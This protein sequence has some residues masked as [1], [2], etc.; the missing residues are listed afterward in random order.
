MSENRPS[1]FRKIRSP[2]PA[3]ARISMAERDYPS[4]GNANTEDVRVFVS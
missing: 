4:T 2:I 1:L 3:V